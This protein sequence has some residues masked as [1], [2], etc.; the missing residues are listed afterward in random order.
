MTP[1]GTPTPAPIATLLLLLFD[2]ETGAVVGGDPVEETG[3]SEIAAVPEELVIVDSDVD[4]VE[5]GAVSVKANV[6]VV[7][8]AI[9]N[10]RF[11][12][13]QVELSAPQHQVP[14]S[15]GVSLGFQTSVSL[16]G[17]RTVGYKR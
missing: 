5:V 8:A 16:S 4:P 13:Q 10:P 12:E 17:L 14:S 11:W 6:P 7:V 2:F 1:R 9:L 15:Q 3:D